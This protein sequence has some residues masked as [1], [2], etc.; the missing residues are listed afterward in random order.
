MIGKLQQ[1]VALHKAILVEDPIWLKPEKPIWKNVLPGS[2]ILIVDWKPNEDMV[3]FL[4]ENV[5]LKIDVWSHMV[6]YNKVEE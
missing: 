1:C 5:V 4:Y 2:I 6:Y 3:Y